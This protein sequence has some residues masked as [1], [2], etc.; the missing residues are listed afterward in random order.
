MHEPISTSAL[1]KTALLKLLLIRQGGT[2]AGNRCMFCITSPAQLA[3]LRREA[4]LAPLKS[5]CVPGVQW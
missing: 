4:R 5:G 1:L 3:M 2:P